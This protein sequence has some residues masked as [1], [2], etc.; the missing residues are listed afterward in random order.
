MEGVRWLFPH[1]R[2]IVT[3]SPFGDGCCRGAEV[4]E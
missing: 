2:P 3:R 4:S 1:H